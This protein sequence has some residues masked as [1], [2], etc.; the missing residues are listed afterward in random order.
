MLGSELLQCAYLALNYWAFREIE[1]GR[2][3]SDLIKDILEGSECYAT[4]GLCLRLAIETFEISET[5]LPIVICQRLWE[6]DMAR[7]I[8]EPQKDIDL[9][10]FGFLT[11]LTGEK[12]KAKAFLDSRKYRKHEVRELAMRF[13]IT[14]DTV[15]RDRF[16]KALAAF[17]DD[18]P[19]DVEEQRGS[20]RLAQNLKEKAELWSGLGDIED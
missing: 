2:S 12:A 1:K 20:E 14:S 4:L 7:L 17:P 3:T 18:L 5:T 19:F 11:K 10:G 13:A 6:H 8:R 15:L 16:K 9:F